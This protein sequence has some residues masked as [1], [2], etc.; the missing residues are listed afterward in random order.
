MRVAVLRNTDNRHDTELLWLLVIGASTLAGWLAL[1]LRMPTPICLFHK[2]TGLP[3]VTCGGTRCMRGL[4]NGDFA[5][6]FLWNPLIFLV[7]IGCVVFALYAAVVVIFRLPRLRLVEI[8]KRQ[9]WLI[10]GGLIFLLAANWAY[11]IWR[12]V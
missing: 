1:L 10:R 3:C 11:L 12:G 8:S 2:I 9:A 5:A 4:I 6:A 7:A